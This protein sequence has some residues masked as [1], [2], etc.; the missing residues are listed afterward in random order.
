M[1]RV[2]RSVRGLSAGD[3]GAVLER[4]GIEPSA[5]PEVVTPVQFATL[6]E[7]LTRTGE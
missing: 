6:F 2:I 1:V 4:A 5:R 3:A 7:L